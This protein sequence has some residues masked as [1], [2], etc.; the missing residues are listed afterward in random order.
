[1][2]NDDARKKAHTPPE[3]HLSSWNSFNVSA[4]KRRRMAYRAHKKNKNNIIHADIYIYLNLLF[5]SVIKIKAKRMNK[6]TKREEM[7]RREKNNA[8]TCHA[9]DVEPKATI[10]NK[11]G[12][13]KASEWNTKKLI[14]IY[15]TDLIAR[16]IFPYRI[17]CVCVWVC[18]SVALCEM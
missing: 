6:W 15:S 8:H 18:C 5:H 13:D 3:F 9:H 14:C 4:H 16:T 10:W 1:M 2:S 12:T 17:I 7:R 11:N